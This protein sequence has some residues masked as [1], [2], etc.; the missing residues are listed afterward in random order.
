MLGNE[1]K[2]MEPNCEFL[3]N[4]TMS[5]SHTH[6][7]QEIRKIIYLDKRQFGFVPD[8]STIDAIFL[9][10]LDQKNYLAMNEPL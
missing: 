10:R 2:P 6:T 7:H 4:L 5:A 3:N 1:I 8:K 9:F